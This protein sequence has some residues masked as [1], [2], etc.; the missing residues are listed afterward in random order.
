MEFQFGYEPAISVR[1]DKCTGQGYAVGSV[2]GKLTAQMS[3]R[4]W[5]KLGNMSSSYAGNSKPLL[6]DVPED[7]VSPSPPQSSRSVSPEHRENGGLSRREDLAEKSLQ[8]AGSA[9]PLPGEDVV[10]R[11]L[12]RE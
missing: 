4:S 8:S 3:R 11:V 5:L 7:A 9:P 6:S 1:V 12:S 2:V 10:V